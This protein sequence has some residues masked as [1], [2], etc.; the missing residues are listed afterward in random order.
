M[1]YDTSPQEDADDYS[2]KDE[3]PPGPVDHGREGGMATREH[4]PELTEDVQAGG[5]GD[6][7]GEPTD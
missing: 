2:A 6:G 3:T 5:G 7:E 1:A 4:A